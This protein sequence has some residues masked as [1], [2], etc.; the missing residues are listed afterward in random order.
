MLIPAGTDERT[1]TWQAVSGRRTLAAGRGTAY[2][3]ALPSVGEVRITVRLAGVASPSVT[4]VSVAP[5]STFVA[6]DLVV[7]GTV[8]VDGALAIDGEALHAGVLVDARGG[9]I[10]YTARATTGGRVGRV[11]LAGASVTLTATANSTGRVKNAISIDAQQQGSETL[12][13]DVQHLDGTRYVEVETP[14]AVAMVKGTRLVV[15]VTE[16]AT[17]V[18]VDHGWVVVRERAEA[19]QHEGTSGTQPAATYDVRDDQQVTIGQHGSS[20]SRHPVVRRVTRRA[21]DVLVATKI[22]AP[23]HSTSAVRE[24]VA[25]TGSGRD[26][27]SGPNTNAPAPPVRKDPRSI[28]GPTP[29]SPTPETRLGD[30]VAGTTPNPKPATGTT[31]APGTTLSP[32]IPTSVPPRDLCPN[33]SGA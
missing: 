6:R 2:E 28:S 11:V 18:T 10:A 16:T 3:I 23:G 26:R 15:V 21:I 24:P 30:A 7:T 33:L 27:D 4:T 14:N 5:V 22:V 31:A 1:M 25:H 8:R 9:R 19:E 17:T 32:G 20:K 29:V 12:V 13:A